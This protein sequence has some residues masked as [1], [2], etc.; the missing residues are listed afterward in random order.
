MSRI[1]YVFDARCGNTAFSDRSIADWY[2]HKIQEE[3]EDLELDK[4]NLIQE[5]YYDQIPKQKQNLLNL[6]KE[7][8]IETKKMIDE[9]LDEMYKRK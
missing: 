8:P 3:Y 9:V 7:C 4:E 6:I 5:Y 2:S 1:I